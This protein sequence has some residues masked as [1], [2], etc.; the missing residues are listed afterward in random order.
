LDE[1]R[2]RPRRQ[3]SLGFGTQKPSRRFI[4][5]ISMPSS[6][7]RVTP[8]PPLAVHGLAAAPEIAIAVGKV[9]SSPM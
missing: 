8:L 3:S 7:L 4:S 9:S 5:A 2:N 6:G 1:R